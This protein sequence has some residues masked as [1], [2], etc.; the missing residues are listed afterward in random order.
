ML[1]KDIS[2]LN[3]RDRVNLDG[4]ESDVW[5][6]ERHVQALQ[7]AGRLLASWQGFVLALAVVISAATGAALAAH[8]S[9]PAAFVAEE[10]LAPSHLLLGSQR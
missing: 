7:A 1:E 6:R 3:A 8:V 4:L 5:R 9:Q 2:R 10:N